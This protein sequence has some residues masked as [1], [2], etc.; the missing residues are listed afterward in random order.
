MHDRDGLGGKRQ[1]TLDLVLRRQQWRDDGIMLG[2][3]EQQWQR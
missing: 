3:P 2:Q 1:W